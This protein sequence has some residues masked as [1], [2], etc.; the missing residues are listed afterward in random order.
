M[1]TYSRKEIFH[2]SLTF[3]QPKQSYQCRPRL[4]LILEKTYQIRPRHFPLF[5][6]LRP[7]PRDHARNL[8]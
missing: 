6:R 3:M 1:I 2:Y 4:L 5:H 8:Q 7:F